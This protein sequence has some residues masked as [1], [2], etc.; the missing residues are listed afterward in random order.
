M[1]FLGATQT[2]TGSR[3]LLD[4]GRSRVLFDCG[5]FQGEKELR[6]RNWEPFPVNPKHID[7]VVISH[8][9]LDH[10]GY[11]PALI[12]A[13][14]HGKVHAT[15]GTFELAKIVLTDSAR[16]QEED[17]A[18]ANRV[19]SSKHH[20]ALPLYTEADSEEAIRRFETHPFGRQISVTDDVTIE[21]HRSGHILGSSWIL[22]HVPGYAPVAFSGDLGRESHPLLRPPEPLESVESLLIEST[23]G[24]RTHDTEDPVK[25]L[26]EAIART[27]ARGGTVIIPSFAVDRTEVVLMH[28]RHLKQNGSIPDLPIF[29]DSPMALEGLR[30]YRRA[31]AERWPELRV[32]NIEDGDPF[33]MDDVTEVRTVEDSKAINDVRYPSIIIAGS[34]MATGGRVLHHLKYRL[35]DSRNAVVIVGYQV[36]GS[37]GRQLVDGAR[38]LKM[39]GEYIDV[40]AEIVNVPGLSVHADR[41][42][43]IG[44]LRTAPS[45]PTTTYVIHGEK[46]ASESLRDAIRSEIGSRAVVPQPGEIVFITQ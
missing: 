2:V 1:R 39:F 34:G 16:L 25:L 11:L 3:F 31:V 45:P 17:A 6:L 18:F 42:E 41:N 4:T 20:P 40:L 33:G 15:I 26:G 24:N 8:A 37:R 23:Y 21:F 9:H 30:V 5:V 43:L 10:V 32:E 12:R 36:P 38:E 14:F 28:L 29:V 13:G 44:W 7:A 19:G 22:I 35:P 46:E 27:S